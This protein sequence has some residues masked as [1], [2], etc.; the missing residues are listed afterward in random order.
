MSDKLKIQQDKV[1]LGSNVI[2]V[3][4]RRKVVRHRGLH[5]ILEYIPTRKL[6]TYT[7]KLLY[8]VTHSGESNTEHEATLEVKTLMDKAATGNN[9]HVRSTD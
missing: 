2:N 5:A 7:L 6:W 4:P 1:N 3:P 9:K 8:P